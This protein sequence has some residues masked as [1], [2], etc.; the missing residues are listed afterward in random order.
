LLFEQLDGHFEVLAS[1][2]LGLELTLELADPVAGLGDRPLGT[3]PQFGPCLITLALRRRELTL[4]PG[5]SL[6]Q[7]PSCLRE[8]P[9][10]L[11]ELGL[12]LCQPGL[13]LCG[14]AFPVCALGLAPFKGGLE[15]L[16]ALPLGLEPG[17][18][19]IRPPI[20]FRSLGLL[21]LATPPFQQ[22]LGLPLGVR[23]PS[24]SI[25]GLRL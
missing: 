10:R 19:L 1:V 3:R 5:A 12:G 7:L 14:A 4:E 16:A 17:L 18:H 20:P 25:Q 6:L 13:G 24:Q 8:L 9:L 21:E 23:E 22:F 11:G 2:A 15:L